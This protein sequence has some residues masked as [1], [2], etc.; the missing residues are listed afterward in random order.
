MDMRELKGL[1]IAARCH[2][3]YKDGK[4]L[5]PSQSGKGKYKVLLSADGDGCECE[6]FQLHRVPCKH[7]HAAR[8]VRERDHHGK[9]PVIDM[10]AVPKRKTYKQNWSAYNLAQMT[11]KHRLQ[12]LL[13]EL[14]QGIEEPIRDPKKT[15]RKPVPM[16]DQLFA[17]AF[18]IYS[19]FSSRRFACDLNDAHGKGYLSR[20]IH[21][22]KVNHFLENPELAP[23][24]SSLILRSSLPLRVVESQFAGDSSGFSTSRFVR[25]YDEKY[26]VTRS[27]KDWVKV[28]IMCG[29]KT[30]VV[31]AI[32]ILDKNAGDSPQLPSL[33]STTAENFTV[34]E[35][36]LDK[37]YLSNDNLALI[38]GFGAA[39][40]IP[41]KSNST[42]GESGSL[43][44]KMFHFFQFQREDFLK[45]Y[46]QRS[47][48]ES[49]FSMVKA[50]FRD[51]VRSKSD[52]AMVNEVLCKFLCHNICCLISAHCELGIEATFWP[53]KEAAGKDDAPALLRFP[54]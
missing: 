13:H 24:L 26:G 7:I 20:P 37:A 12:I 49:T 33:V 36:S 43:W 34:K 39:P 18:K 4:W 42:A 15:G 46:H 10:D 52:P 53:E 19:T 31:T 9:S 45:H 8:L 21:P 48:V 38:A 2:I 25:W 28:H 44:E 3:G 17:C 14:C 27:G 54:G 22:N 32:E 1:E 5:V 30:N 23:V 47:N 41:F 16:A 29:V 40:F 6:D 35:V 11:E 51:H 50:K